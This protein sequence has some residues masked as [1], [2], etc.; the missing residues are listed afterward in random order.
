MNQDSK[1]MNDGF[2]QL[3]QTQDLQEVPSYLESKIMQK[4]E[5]K[6][7][8]KPSLINI[9]SIFIFGLLVSFYVLMSFM[10][11]YY[12]PHSSTLQDCRTLFLIGMLVHVIYELNEII[13]AIIFEKKSLQNL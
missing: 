4:I 5:S 7:A 11:V 1:I 10:N 2:Y 12:F 3:M 13:P 6:K 8:L 9:Q